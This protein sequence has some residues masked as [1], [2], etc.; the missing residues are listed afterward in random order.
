MSTH[1]S[2]HPAS[3]ATPLKLAVIL[4]SVREARYGPT[5]SNWF[6]E[7]AQRH[8]GFNVDTI[9]LADTQLPAALP[10][11]PEELV[12]VAGRSAEMRALSARLASADGFVVVTPEYNHSFP[13]SIKHFVDWHFSEWQAK[14]VGFVSYGGAAS[15][16]RAVE[17][18]RLV[19]AELH[20]VTMRDVVSFNRFEAPFD[21]DGRPAAP[22]EANGAAKELLDQLTWWATALHDARSK[23]PYAMAD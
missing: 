13:A 2:T 4:G 5:V 3:A 23:S 21:A 14:P 15:G 10:P 12:D 18:L 1:E 19:F 16:L 20:A 17:G 22:T 8:G 6:V 11:G 9:D 7:E